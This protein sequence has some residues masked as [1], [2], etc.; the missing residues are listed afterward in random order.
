MGGWELGLDAWVNRGQNVPHMPN[1]RAKEAVAMP[2]EGDTCVTIVNSE[3][4]V[5]LGIVWARF[6]ERASACQCLAGHLACGLV[7]LFCR[8]WYKYDGERYI[9]TYFLYGVL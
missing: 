7:L 2:S 3:S 4:D 5:P 6:S 1:G 9:R 8:C